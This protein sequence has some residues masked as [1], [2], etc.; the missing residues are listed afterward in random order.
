MRTQAWQ[1]IPAGL[2]ISWLLAGHLAVAG[3]PAT[4]VAQKAQKAEKQE[5]VWLWTMGP[6]LNEGWAKSQKISTQDVCSAEQLIKFYGARQVM[7]FE[8]RPHT[9][10][11]AKRFA[12]AER[13]VLSSAVFGAKSESL[14]SLGPCPNLAGMIIDDFSSNISRYTPA[15]LADAHRRLKA[16]GAHLKLYTVIY[17]MH[18]DLD[19]KPYLPFMDVVSLWVWESKDLGDLDRHL[20]RCRK[21]F[22]GKPIVLG[23]YLYEY[24]HDRF[25]PLDLVQWEF[26][27][28]RDYARRGLIDGY[29]VLGSYLA[30]E[31]QT[32]QG[33]WVRD[34]IGAR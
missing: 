5:E 3:E 23:L 22:P 32:P 29:Q 25:V 24:P 18:F 34:F 26:R 6:D 30:K 27:K 17:T 14:E 2:A 28:A 8:S 9:P 13:L 31:L 15:S 21:I 33:R 4:P 16:R 10:E 1:S 11:V 7:Y 20:E 19:F 12:Q